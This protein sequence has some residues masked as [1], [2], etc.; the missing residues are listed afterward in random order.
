VSF[1]G[2]QEFVEGI[3]PLAD[4]FILPSLHESFGLSA[5]EAMAAGLPVVVTNQGGPSE[6]VVEGECGFL[7]A[8]D[9]VEGMSE[10]VARLFRNPDLARSFGEAGHKRSREVFHADRVVPAYLRAYGA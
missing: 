8:P 10:A 5:L 3:F 9:D 1:L 6:V 7:R 4:V 2:N